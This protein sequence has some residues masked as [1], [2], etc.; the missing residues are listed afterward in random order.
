[1]CER[2]RDG[3]SGCCKALAIPYGFYLETGL[4]HGF[5]CHHI[6]ILFTFPLHDMYDEYLTQIC[7]IGLI[8][9]FAIKLG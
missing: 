7:I 5:S 3:W 4:F 6:S 8:I 1:M 9:N 2:C